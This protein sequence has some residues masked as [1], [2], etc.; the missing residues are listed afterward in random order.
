MQ[1]DMQKMLQH[2]MLTRYIQNLDN[3]FQL[4][5]KHSV[6]GNASVIAIGIYNFCYFSE[7]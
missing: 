5:L 2:F 4:I 7:A 3:K 6:D 1:S